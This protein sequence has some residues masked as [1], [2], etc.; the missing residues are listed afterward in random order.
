MKRADRLFLDANVLFSAAYRPDAGICRL[1]HLKR[2]ELMSSG[3]A[4]TEARV[5][6][7]D[8]GQPHRLQ[9]LLEHVSMVTGLAPLP[10]GVILPDKD[11]PI[12]QAAIYGH[13]THLLTGDKQH[14]G[15]Y[16]GRR[17]GGVLVLPPAGY[18]RNLSAAGEPTACRGRRG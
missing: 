4:A 7:A 1:W 16:Y 15:N 6:L 10:P 18:I 12:L 3:Y 13:A 5:N 14:F 9:E 8:V 11:Q 17:L 2:V